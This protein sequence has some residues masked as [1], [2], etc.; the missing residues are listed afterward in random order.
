[1]SEDPNAFVEHVREKDRAHRKRQAEH[2]TYLQRL[3]RNPF[4][5]EAQQGIEKIIHENNVHK[6]YEHAMEHNPEVFGSVH[7]LYVN[8]EVRPTC[9]LGRP[10]PR[11][12]PH[13]CS[14]CPP[15]QPRRA[16]AGQ[17]VNGVPM[18]AFVDCGAQVSPSACPSALARAPQLS[19]LRGPSTA[20]LFW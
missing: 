8:A 20:V 7:M 14:S 1:M 4:D 17:Q 9:D 10:V 18:K 6:N 3:E 11:G 16:G 19:V 5:K 12:R 13:S 15:T 2:T